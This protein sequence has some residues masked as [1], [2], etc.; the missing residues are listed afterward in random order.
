MEYCQ[1]L[2]TLIEKLI[3]SEEI[4]LTQLIDHISSTKACKASIKAGQKLSYPEM[5]Q[6]V[7]D[8]FTSIDDMFVCQHGR[9]FWW[10]MDKNDI[11]GMFDR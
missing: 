1:D 7:Q 3:H 5:Q 8:G 9:P 2:T 6:L 11:D 4:S 10:E